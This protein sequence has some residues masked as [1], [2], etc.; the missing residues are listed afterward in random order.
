MKEQV[1]FEHHLH[2]ESCFVDVEAER[3]KH[4]E[5]VKAN[6]E[7]GWPATGWGGP[8]GTAPTQHKPIVLDPEWSFCP[9][10]GRRI[11]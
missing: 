9:L 7:K 11:R 10:C 1:C 4:L 5:W 2:D 6:C 8:P 3:R